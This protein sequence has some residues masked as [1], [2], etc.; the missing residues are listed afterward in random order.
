MMRQFDK[1]QL[2]ATFDAIFSRQL[3]AETRAAV[4]FAKI[5][6]PPRPVHPILYL[7]VE[8]KSR[9]L[10]GKAI[11]AREVLEQGLNVVIGSAW[12]MVSWHDKMPP[13]IFFF[14]TMNTGDAQNMLLWAKHGHLIAALDEEMFGVRADADYISAT[15]HPRAPAL[16]DLVCAQGA[17]YARAFPFPVPLKITGNPRTKTYRLSRGTDILVCLQSGNINN[18]GR[19]F[20]EMVKKTLGLAQPLG[21]REGRAWAEILRASIAH[22]CDVLPLMAATIAA[23]ATAFPDR[24]VVVRPHPVEDPATWQF[25]QGNVVLDGG[26]GIVDA[27]EKAGTAIFVSGCTTG[28]DAY[29]AGVPAVRLGSGGHGISAE[30]YDGVTTAGEAVEAVRRAKAWPGSIADHLAPLD[31][32]SHLVALYRASP[33]QGNVQLNAPAGFEPTDFRRGKFPDMTDA[34]MEELLGHKVQRIAWNTFFVAARTPGK[35]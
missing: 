17:A 35:S 12:P 10:Q 16:A 6:K 2:L 13:G 20:E 27:L 32:A 25:E 26:E 9:E 11:L 18:H 30:M 19:S 33:G 29:L 23:V 24:R 3:S 1:D 14:K 31:L 15:V 8:V 4:S 7:P 21:T 22:E 28:L 5:E 34:E